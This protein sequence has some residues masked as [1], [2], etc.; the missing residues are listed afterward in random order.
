MADCP[1]PRHTFFRRA[2][3]QYV[4]GE[5][6]AT[7]VRC[8]LDNTP[9]T[10]RCFDAI[11]SNNDGGGLEAGPHHVAPV[12]VV[13]GSRGSQK[14]WWRGRI[15]IWIPVADKGVGKARTA[16]SEEARKACCSGEASVE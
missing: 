10:A 5:V 8:Q 4:I 12:S 13:E 16:T 2:R 9:S 14:Q 1:A 11:R 15:P 3:V 6:G 7:A